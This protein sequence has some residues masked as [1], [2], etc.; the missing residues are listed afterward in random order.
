MYTEHIQGLSQRLFRFIS[1]RVT[2]NSA[3]FTSWSR[4][5]QSKQCRMACTHTPHQ[6]LL[7]SLV[8]SHEAISRSSTTITIRMHMRT[9]VAVHTRLHILVLWVIASSASQG[10]LC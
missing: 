1:L 3:G 2:N 7:N 10:L 8:L 9:P 6:S 5:S 4:Q